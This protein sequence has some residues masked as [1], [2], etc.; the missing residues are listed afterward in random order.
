MITQSPVASIKQKQLQQRI[1][2]LIYLE[3]RTKGMIQ[4]AIHEEFPSPLLCYN[5]KQ[6]K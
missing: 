4:N 6:P 2:N 3:D 5:Q 1:R